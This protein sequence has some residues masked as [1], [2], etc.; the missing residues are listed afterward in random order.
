M[1]EKEEKHISFTR[2]T[3]FAAL[4]LAVLVPLDLLA[5][6][7]VAMGAVYICIRAIRA[8][9]SWMLEGKLEV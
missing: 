2:V 9:Q 6:L 3:G 1:L 7:A 4:G 8:S 5:F